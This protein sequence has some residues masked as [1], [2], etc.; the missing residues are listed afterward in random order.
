MSNI[1][2]PIANPDLVSPPGAPRVDRVIRTVEDDDEEGH[3]VNEHVRK[4]LN[5]LD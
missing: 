5:F 1:T 3:V 2:T 4:K